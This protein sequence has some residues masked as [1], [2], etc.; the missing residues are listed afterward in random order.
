MTN[1]EKAIVM[2]Y[3]GFVMLCGNQLSIFYEYV[4]EL[5]GR[6]VYTH[7][8]P[9][10]A[11]EIQRRSKPDFI[12]LCASDNGWTRVEDGRPTESGEYLTAFRYVIYDDKLSD[13]V[14]VGLDSFRGKTEWA[15]KAN[16]RVLAWMPKPAPPEVL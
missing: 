3:T 9:E 4:V 6:P 10:L 7:E 11:D 12:K 1:R 5:F 16:R 8:L 13:D 15:K 14:H 2:A